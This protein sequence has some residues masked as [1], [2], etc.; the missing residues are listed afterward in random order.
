MVVNQLTLVSDT[1]DGGVKKRLYSVQCGR[2]VLRLEYNR[3]TEKWLLAEI[4]VE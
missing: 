1:R 3:E 4:W 2:E